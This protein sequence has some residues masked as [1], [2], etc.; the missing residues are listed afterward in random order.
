MSN[1]ADPLRRESSLNYHRAQ[2][3]A[4][5]HVHFVKQFARVLRFTNARAA[6]SRPEDRKL[7][8]RA[9]PAQREHYRQREYPS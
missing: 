2:Q 8:R 7:V 9:A 1:S 5:A 4:H 3:H 6:L